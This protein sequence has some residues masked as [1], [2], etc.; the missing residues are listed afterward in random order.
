MSYL[1]RY[2]RTRI[3]PTPSGFLHLGN[4]ASFLCTASL[5]GQTGARL[6]L[7]IDDLDQQRVRPDYIQDIFDTLAFLQIRWD[8]GPRDPEDYAAH[9]AQVHRLGLY[10]EALEQLRREG[11]VF[12]C[13]CSRTRLLQDHPQGFY[14]GTC[15]QKGIPLDEPG[16][17]WRLHTDLQLSLPVKNSDGSVH[18]ALLPPAMQAFVV[19]RKD[20]IPS[21]QL[22]SLVDDLH[23]GVDLVVRGA[24][25]WPSTLAQLYLAAVLGKTAFLQTAF[26][27]HPLLPGPEGNKLSKSAGAES[28]RHLRSQGLG[29]EHLLAQIAGLIC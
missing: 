3:A 18:S 26:H 8:E 11:Q 4:A 19:R 2:N 7:R 28:I 14:T 6:L 24:D 23:F 10:A 29:R 21:Y 9:Y 25:L 27:H 17:S 1:P 13:T 20:G 22:A 15:S 16:V 12:A 5:A